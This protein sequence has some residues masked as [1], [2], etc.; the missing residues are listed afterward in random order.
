M[1]NENK[2]PEEFE[3]L[4]ELIKGGQHLEEQ[5]WN[6]QEKALEEHKVEQRAQFKDIHNRLDEIEEKQ[7]DLSIE[8][9]T[10]KVSILKAK[11]DTLEKSKKYIHRI[12]LF[13]F[14]TIPAS[15]FVLLRIMLLLKKT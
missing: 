6:W 5:R 14:V 8:Q 11:D 4:R 13:L 7:D 15:I 1:E 3:A 9:G 12:L 2:M 10:Q